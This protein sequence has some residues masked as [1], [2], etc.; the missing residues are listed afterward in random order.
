MPLATS[1]QDGARGA[2]CRQPLLRLRACL[3]VSAGVRLVAQWDSSD[4]MSAS[5][6]FSTRRENPEARCLTS[7]PLHPTA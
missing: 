1:A 2:D 7:L 3:P 6:R 5:A 4:S